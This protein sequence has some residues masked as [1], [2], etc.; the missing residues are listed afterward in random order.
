MA[1]EAGVGLNEVAFMGDDLPDLP[2]LRLAG[3]AMTV[4]DAVVQVREICDLVTLAPGGRAAV[5]EAVEHLV[6]ARGAMD[7]WLR[8]YD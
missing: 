6:R 3:F 8:R 2:A 1:G 4:A 5:R 7:E